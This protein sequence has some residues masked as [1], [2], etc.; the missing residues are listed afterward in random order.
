MPTV[1]REPFPAPTITHQIKIA[2]MPTT[3]SLQSFTD[4]I[5]I[6]LSQDGALSQWISV[7]LLSSTPIAD[8]LPDDDEETKLLPLS[9][10]QPK[11][12]LGGGGDK[13]QVMGQLFATQI[14]TAI[15]TKNPGEE[16][17]VLLGL[18]IKLDSVDQEGW[19][20]FVEGVL[21]IL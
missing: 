1:T 8:P 14:A 2:S 21:G 4:K 7:S 12:L 16:R 6:I 9:H 11:T 3:I 19:L 17:T 10:L 18:G 13:R 15:K 5:L 20:D